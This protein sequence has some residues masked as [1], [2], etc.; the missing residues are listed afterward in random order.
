MSLF[1]VGAFLAAFVRYT[2]DPMFKEAIIVIVYSITTTPLLYIVL[3]A[4]YVLFLKVKTTTTLEQ[5]RRLSYADMQNSDD[6][7]DSAIRVNWQLFPDRVLNPNSY[8]TFCS[9]V[10]AYCLIGT[11]VV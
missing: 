11:V 6:E 2:E 1:E 10:L 8:G 3:Y 4:V 9:Y 5:Q 7:M